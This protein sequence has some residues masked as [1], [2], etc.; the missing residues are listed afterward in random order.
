MYAH[1]TVSRR[2]LSPGGHP[3]PLCRLFSLRPGREDLGGRVLLC[4]YVRV[5]STLNSKFHLYLR[6]SPPPGT[7]SPERP[8]TRPVPSEGPSQSPRL[9]LGV[10][11]RWDFWSTPPPKTR[12]PIYPFEGPNT[13]FRIGHTFRLFMFIPTT[14]CFDYK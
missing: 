5:P 12:F 8:K 9:V 3:S 7:L 14:V 13:L 4:L 10:F 11:S 1:T 6:W 2:C